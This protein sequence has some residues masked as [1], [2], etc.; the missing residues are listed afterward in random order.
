MKIT[1]MNDMRML[2]RQSL[3][4]IV[5]SGAAMGQS[6][7]PYYVAAA[8]RNNPSI[9]ESSNTIQARNLDRALN[10][11]QLSGPQVSLTANYLF[12]PFFNNSPMVTSNSGPNA[13]GY[14]ASIT[15]GGL[16]AAQLNVSKNLFTGGTLGAYDAQTSLQIGSAENAI[17]VTRHTV[18]HDVTDQYLVSLQAQQLYELAK[19]SADTLAR[20]VSITRSLMLQGMAKESDYLLLRIE[21]A[22]E[23]IAVEEASGSYQ[24]ALSELNT[25]CGLVDSSTIGLKDVELSPSSAVT[26]SGFLRQY[27]LDS[28]LLAGQRAVLETKYLPQV[29]IFANA[30]LNAIELQGIE[31]KFGMSAGVN[32]SLRLFDGNQKSIARQQ[33]E[34]AARGIEEQKENQNVR[35]RN[36]KSEIAARLEGYSRS[37]K[38]IS[39]QLQE[40]GQIIALAHSQL[41]HGQLTMIEFLTIQKNYLELKK[42]EIQTHIAYEQMINHLN[43]W[44]W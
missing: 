4:L 27:A 17:E 19:A 31:R 7:L 18:E 24:S 10:N 38:A 32:F 34:I 21:L 15:N 23:R 25:L 16:Y 9:K 44:N 28:M 5:L 20:Q 30:G 33:S 1:A 35:I 37:R 22:N 13:I 14:D 29:S 12:A 2:L 39:E 36:K 42:K 40:Y 8:L 11:A 6:D 3:L 43:Y 41:V 26:E